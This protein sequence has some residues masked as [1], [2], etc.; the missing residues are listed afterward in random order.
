MK[1]K[2]KWQTEENQRPE[3]CKRLGIVEF[4]H[5]W[6]LQADIEMRKEL[7]QFLVPIRSQYDNRLFLDSKDRMVCYCELFKE[8]EECEIVPTYEIIIHA[9]DN[10][11]ESIEVKEKEKY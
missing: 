8:L 10:K 9:K 6:L 11:I 5:Y 3:I 2:E 7:Y 4:T 1:E